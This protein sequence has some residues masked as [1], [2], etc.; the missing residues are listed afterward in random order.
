MAPSL[1]YAN[2]GPIDDLRELAVGAESKGLFTRIAKRDNGRERLS[3]LIYNHRAFL[4]F[5]AYSESGRDAFLNST[6]AIP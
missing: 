2:P 1:F 5:V 3:S 4:A 6:F